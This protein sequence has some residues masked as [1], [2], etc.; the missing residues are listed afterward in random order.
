MLIIEVNYIQ[1]I[2]NTLAMCPY[3]RQFVWTMIFM[4]LDFLAMRLDGA[5]IWGYEFARE[6][7]NF[8]CSRVSHILVK[9]IF[10]LKGNNFDFE[11]IIFH[12]RHAFNIKSL[13]QSW[14]HENQR[15]FSRCSCTIKS[16]FGSKQHNLFLFQ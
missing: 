6:K 5:S 1:T 11:S 14:R 13:S 15:R 2:K 3:P 8:T 7:T 10:C 9:I 12:N 4:T 16:F